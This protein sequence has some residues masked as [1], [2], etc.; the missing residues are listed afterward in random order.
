MGILNCRIRYEHLETI[1]KMYLTGYLP[2]QRA[3][4]DWI[5]AL[6]SLLC[7]SRL[8]LGEIDSGSSAAEALNLPCCE[9]ARRLTESKPASFC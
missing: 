2:V 1:D 5:E 8:L 6:L 7:K 4:F 3:T 9:P